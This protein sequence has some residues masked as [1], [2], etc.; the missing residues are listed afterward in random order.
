[1]TTSPF[2]YSSWPG[3]ELKNITT[4]KNYYYQL[5]SLIRRGKGVVDRVNY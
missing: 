1:M 3:G 5:P 2:G 4:I